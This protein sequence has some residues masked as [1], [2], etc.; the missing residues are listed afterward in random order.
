MFEDKQ[1]KEW[2]SNNKLP[3]GFADWL[4]ETIR[5][6][7]IN[8]KKGFRHIASELGVNPSMLS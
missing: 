2:S 3:G 4:E 5:D 7:E 6:N 1:Y 8:H